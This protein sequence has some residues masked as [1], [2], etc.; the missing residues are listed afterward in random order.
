MLE[1]LQLEFNKLKNEVE[2]YR[3][4][5]NLLKTEYEKKHYKNPGGFKLAFVPIPSVGCLSELN[6]FLLISNLESS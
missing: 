5:C 6:G 3:V 1:Q 4:K 2:N